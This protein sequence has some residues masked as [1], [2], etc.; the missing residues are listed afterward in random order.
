MKDVANNSKKTAVVP[1]CKTVEQCEHLGKRS[2]ILGSWLCTLNKVMILNKLKQILSSEFFWK[3][4]APKGGNPNSPLL[5]SSNLIA[6][7]AFLPNSAF[8]KRDWDAVKVNTN[9]GK[10]GQQPVPLKQCDEC[11]FTTVNYLTNVPSAQ[12]SAKDQLKNSLHDTPG[13]CSCKNV[14]VRTGIASTH[15]ALSSVPKIRRKENRWKSRKLS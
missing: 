15:T 4:S 1:I 8:G 12:W 14:K 6:H 11:P 9:N 13:Q 2:N 5:H 10:A 3:C 7:S